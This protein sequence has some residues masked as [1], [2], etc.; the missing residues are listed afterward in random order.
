MATKAKVGAN[1]FLVADLFLAFRY[2][3]RLGFRVKNSWWN[4]KENRVSKT[5]FRLWNKR[6]TKNL[7]SI[8][9]PH[10]SVLTAQEGPRSINSQKQE[11]LRIRPHKPRQNQGSSLKQPTVVSLEGACRAGIDTCR[12][13]IQI[14]SWVALKRSGLEKCGALLGYKL[15][16]SRLKET[17]LGVWSED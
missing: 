2:C 16:I 6:K 13:A 1:E 17:S 3:S 12:A 7:R 8:A 4:E 11:V 15:A 14:R 10:Q 9:I 5:R